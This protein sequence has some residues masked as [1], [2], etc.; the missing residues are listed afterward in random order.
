MKK[1]RFSYSCLGDYY[2]VEIE[3]DTL[4]QAILWFAK[5]YHQI[6]EVFSIKE[7]LI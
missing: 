7:I 1:F 6:S 5:Y 4:N 3:K 2:T